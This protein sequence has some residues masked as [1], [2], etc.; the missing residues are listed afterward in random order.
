M[1]EDVYV[2]INGR[3]YRLEGAGLSTLS[4]EEFKQEVL[5]RLDAMESELLSQRKDIQSL[6]TAMVQFDKTQEG[7]IHDVDHVQ[8]TVYWGFALIGIFIAFVSWWRARESKPEPTPSPIT[9][10][11]P[12][13][14]LTPPVQD[15]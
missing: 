14:L 3:S 15:K 10:Q 5:T 7:L 6:T 8:T 13:S 11:F 2:V 1:S 12:P 4:D 9:I